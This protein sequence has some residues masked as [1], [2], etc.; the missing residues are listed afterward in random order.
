MEMSLINAPP[1]FDIVRK[2][3][4]ALVDGSLRLYK[5]FS[6]IT[7]PDLAIVPL[8]HVKSILSKIVDRGGPE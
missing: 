7:W 4:L 8:A 2:T 1:S 5:T 3:Y 6:E